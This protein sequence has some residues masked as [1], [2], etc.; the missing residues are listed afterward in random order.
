[1]I[2]EIINSMN[3]LNSL[4]NTVKEKINKLEGRPKEIIQKSASTE[5][6]RGR[7]SMI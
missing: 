3:M 4:L 5:G 6:N 1:M 7:E 2:V